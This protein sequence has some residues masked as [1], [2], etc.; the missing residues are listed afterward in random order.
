M[1]AIDPE[2]T[3]I[4]DHDPSPGEPGVTGAVGR[5]QRYHICKCKHLK[6]ASKPIKRA[7]W[8]AIEWHEL[9][10]CTACKSKFLD[11]DDE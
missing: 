9:E 3:K 2:G 5:S 4:E 1:S 8:N 11:S 6:G 10:L 7:T